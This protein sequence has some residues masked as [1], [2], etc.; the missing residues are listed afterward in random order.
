[1]SLIG[2]SLYLSVL[3]SVCYGFIFNHITTK[4]L[5][6][7]VNT[8][9]STELPGNDFDPVKA[10]AGAIAGAVFGVLISIGF[11][12]F[13]CVMYIRKKRERDLEYTRRTKVLMQSSQSAGVYVDTTQ[14]LSRTKNINNRGS[15]YKSLQKDPN[16]YES[17]S[18]DEL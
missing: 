2:V 16:M 8:T 1:M 9:Q 3:F 15:E 17:D 4:T 6:D 18:E 5:L 13:A 12:T 14:E 7:H 11:I 10:E